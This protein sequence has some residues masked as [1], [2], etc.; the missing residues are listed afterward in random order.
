[1]V[2]GG[3]R[4][5]PIEKALGEGQEQDIGS[6]QVDI[7]LKLGSILL[8]LSQH[9]ERKVYPPQLERL[10]EGEEVGSMTAADI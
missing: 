10:L 9:R 2:V 8:S 3:Y 7:K 5:C 6:D 4:N 1:M